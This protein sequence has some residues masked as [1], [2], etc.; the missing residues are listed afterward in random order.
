MNQ[1]MIDI[2]PFLVPPIACAIVW[3]F[4]EV[5]AL[6]AQI[7]F[8]EKTIIGMRNR[9]DSHSKKQDDTIAQM[10]SMEKEVLTQMGSI[11]ED[12]ATLASK[13]EGLHNLIAIC[14]QGI[15][16]PRK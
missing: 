13:L 4:R 8:F 15:N 11:R 14:N 6:I 7:K 1:V 2:W 9:L 3:L 16:N 5:F 10:S 12:I